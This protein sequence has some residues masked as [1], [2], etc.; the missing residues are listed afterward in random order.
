MRQIRCNCGPDMIIR[1]P[2]PGDRK[3]GLETLQYSQVG[4][5]G[6]PSAQA[7]ALVTLGNS[8]RLFLGAFFENVFSPK[9]WQKNSQN[10]KIPKCSDLI[11]FLWFYPFPYANSMQN[12]S[13][14]HLNTS[15]ACFEGSGTGK[16][17]KKHKTLKNLKLAPNKQLGIYIYM[18]IPY[19]MSAC[20]WSGY[21]AGH[22][23]AAWM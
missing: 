22:W 10:C 2:G 3:I 19:V 18:Y 12:T 20:A 14:M 6:H 17:E 9:G 13:P 21:H 5:D 1:V 23:I 4:M 15:P 16:Q 8:G 11:D 7:R